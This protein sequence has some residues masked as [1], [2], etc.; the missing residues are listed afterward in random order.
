M[1][2]D[3][4][5]LERAEMQTQSNNRRARSPP[6]RQLDQ[7]P[8]SRQPTHRDPRCIGARDARPLTKMPEGLC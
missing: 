1:G 4:V 8:P 7:D 2:G 5:R 3:V 6:T